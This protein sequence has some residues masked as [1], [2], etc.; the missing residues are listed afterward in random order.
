[1]RSDFMKSDGD[2]VPPIMMFILSVI[3]I[4]TLVGV[5]LWFEPQW[6]GFL[7]NIL[8]EEEVIIENFDDRDMPRR[9]PSLTWDLKGGEK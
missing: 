2:K 1:M 7:D 5:A 9:P 3:I 6:S 8:T 4:A